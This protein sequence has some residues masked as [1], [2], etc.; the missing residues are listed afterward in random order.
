MSDANCVTCGAS[1][2]LPDDV[3]IGEILDCGDCG[4]ELEVVAETP[5]ELAEAPDLAEDWGE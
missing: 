3:E 4:T 1:V 5:V 2:V